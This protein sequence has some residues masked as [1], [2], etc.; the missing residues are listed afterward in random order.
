MKTTLL[1]LMVILMA[2]I[3]GAQQNPRPMP[4]HR[5][6][7]WM[8][9]KAIQHPD[10]EFFS[11]VR[12]FTSRDFSRSGVTGDLSRF[13]PDST[14]KFSTRS[15]I[16]ISGK[17]WKLNANPLLDL[18]YTNDL[19]INSQYYGLPVKGAIGIDLSLELGADWHLGYRRLQSFADGG[20]SDYIQ[21]T[22][23][24]LSAQSF[25]YSDAFFI[26]ANPGEGMNLHNNNNRS[27][28]ESRFIESWISWTPHKYFQIM[29]G[30]GKH[31]FGEGYRSLTLSDNAYNY[32]YLRTSTSFWKIKY[33]HLLAAPD[34]VMMLDN[35]TVRTTR[36]FMAVQSL[37]MK[38]SR[39]LYAS[40]TESV[41]WERTQTGGNK[42]WDLNYLNPVVFYH[43]INYSLNSMGNAL[44]ALGL[45]Y[46]IRNSITAY[47]Q[48]ILDDFNFEGLRTGNGFFQNKV[49]GQ[50]GVKAFD[51]FNLKGLIVLAEL[52]MIR[53]YTYSNRQPGISYSHQ[54]QALA[55]PAGANL[56]EPVLILNYMRNGA[57]VEIKN[58]FLVSGNDT[59]YSHYGADILKDESRVNP[60]SY[61]NVYL[62]GLR[63]HSLRSE[64][65]LAKIIHQPTMLTGEVIM[66]TI[67]QPGFQHVT[68][69][70]YRP[71]QI[72]FVGFGIR[73]Q[74]YNF[75][76]DRI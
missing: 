20:Y 26:T 15:I 9:E 24:R 14:R 76:R 36:K 2:Q 71:K 35:G 37:E 12:P 39:R 62:Q 38:L 66:G 19:Y 65:R 29:A 42:T 60:Y 33:T 69:L 46:K 17:T 45:K 27:F 21:I 74:L 7:A 11:G 51:L 34:N 75:Y 61:G 5:D 59:Y 16:Q 54:A 67:V 22:K 31:F 68:T 30:Q 18:S 50:L 28:Y 40:L 63:R 55:H 8:Y 6:A 23:P 3:L 64:I 13:S 1:F 43:P 72:L 53:P 32:P 73:C 25:L 58:T 57:T 41:I 70:S 49:A 56:F 44:L 47:G 48:F 4:L 10:Q 52:N